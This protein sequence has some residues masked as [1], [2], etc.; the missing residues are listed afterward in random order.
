MSELTD[1]EKQA[2][3][4]DA[5]PHYYIKKMK[6]VNKILVE[7]PLEELL[8]YALNIEEAVVNPGNDT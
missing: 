1:H 5:L 7:M 3:F 8:S 6:E 2:T 4:Y